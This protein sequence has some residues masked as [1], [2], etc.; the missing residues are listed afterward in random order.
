MPKKISK[1]FRIGLGSKIIIFDLHFILNNNHLKMNAKK[2]FFGK[3]S[4][5]RTFLT[6]KNNKELNEI[7]SIMVISFVVSFLVPIERTQL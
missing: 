7:L 4:N 2:A 5:I 6:I 1:I 3:L